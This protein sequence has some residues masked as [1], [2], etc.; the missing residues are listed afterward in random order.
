MTNGRLCARC[1]TWPSVIGSRCMK[2]RV[3]ECVRE[4]KLDRYEWW[5]PVEPAFVAM[6]IGRYMNDG[7]GEAPPP[8]EEVLRSLAIR[9]KV[10]QFRVLDEVTALIDMVDRAR[11]K[12]D[13]DSVRDEE[14]GRRL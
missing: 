2:C 7:R 3:R 1:K 13:A 12:R 11:R 8:V 5:R 9:S 14:G 10:K 4:C 6:M